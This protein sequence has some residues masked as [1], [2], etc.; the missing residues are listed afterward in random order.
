MINVGIVMYRMV[1]L[2]T[3]LAVWLSSFVII[4]QNRKLK[5]GLNHYN[6][7]IKVYSSLKL[8]LPLPTPTTSVDEVSRRIYR[9][10]S[11]GDQLSSLGIG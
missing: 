1:T 4:H 8:P 10:R 2:F 3:Y 6:K 11:C 7:L 5:C 9:K